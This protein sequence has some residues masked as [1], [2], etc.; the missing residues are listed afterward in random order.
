MTHYIMV[1]WVLLIAISNAVIPPG[2]E[3]MTEGCQDKM[4]PIT[5]GG[6]FDEVVNCTLHDEQN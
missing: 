1:I 3:T 4:F 5:V 6:M 2:W